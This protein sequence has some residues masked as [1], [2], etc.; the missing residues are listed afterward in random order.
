MLAAAYPPPR[1]TGRERA[2]AG[3][4][5]PCAASENRMLAH[6][7][8]RGLGR[9]GCVRGPG[10]AA[11][12]FLAARSVAALANMQYLAKPRVR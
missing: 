1:R 4:D 6:G 10:Q 11:R 5:Q 9:T 3:S 2:R 12:G 7:A 8:G